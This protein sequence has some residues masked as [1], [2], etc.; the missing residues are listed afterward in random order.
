MQGL[1]EFWTWVYIIG[2]GAFAAVAIVV[3]PLGFRDL[4]QLLKELGEH[5]GPG[6]RESDE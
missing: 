2:F 6:D 1:Q 4:L 3:I 5:H